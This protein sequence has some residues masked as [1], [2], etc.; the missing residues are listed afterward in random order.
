MTAV[1]PMPVVLIDFPAASD[2]TN[3]LGRADFFTEHVIEFWERAQL[4]NVQL[5]APLVD[6]APPT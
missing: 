6:Q 4:F 1:S 3:I 5:P 2:P